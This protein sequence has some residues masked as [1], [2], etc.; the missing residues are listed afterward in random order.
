M[1]TPQEYITIREA[2]DLLGCGRT[3]IY[4]YYLN[5]DL[6]EIKRK[7]GNRS[8]LLKSDVLAILRTETGTQE[9]LSPLEKSSQSQSS[10]NRSPEVFTPPGWQSPDEAEH[11][12]VTEYISELKQ[13]AHSLSQALAEKDE[14][15]NQYKSK[16]LNSVPLSE[17]SDKMK[18]KDEEL[19]RQSEALEQVQVRASQSEEQSKKLQEKNESLQ[20]K[21]SKSLKVAVFYQRELDDERTHHAH[22][23]KLHKRWTLL[24]SRL[25]ACGF[26]DWGQKRQLRTELSQVKDAIKSLE[27]N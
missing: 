12:I 20:G 4:T 25:D 5:N 10:E 8:Y 26:F 3:K 7:K 6:L 2:C 17:F 11:K 22:F 14:V 15:L 21:F 1:E 18:Q 24:Q 9:H 16:L 23:E 13:R 19:E 27:K